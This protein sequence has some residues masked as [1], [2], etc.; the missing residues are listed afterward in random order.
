MTCSG[1]VF[2]DRWWSFGYLCGDPSTRIADYYPSPGGGSGVSPVVAVGAG[3]SV[4]ET[5]VVAVGAGVSVGGIS[6][7]GG[8]SVVGGASCV[9]V[10]VSVGKIPLVGLGVG[11]TKGGGV[12]VIVG[13]I[14]V[15]PVPDGV[16]VE[17]EHISAA[18][19][20]NA[21]NDSSGRIARASSYWV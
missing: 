15:V 7:V 16:G 21:C 12:L 5:S 14:V 17:G 8:T 19:I 1:F 18:C 10:G 9:A 3:V 11:V 2:F 13:V 4:G 20:V 6:V